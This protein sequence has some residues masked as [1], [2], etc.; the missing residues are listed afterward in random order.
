MNTTTKV[1]TLRDE[2]YWSAHS[3]E[4]LANVVQ[5]FD[6]LVTYYSY[7]GDYEL[8]D[9]AVEIATAAYA[10]LASR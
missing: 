9:E 7:T 1:I 2:E 5:K 3:D 4:A 10:Q 8:M 6:A